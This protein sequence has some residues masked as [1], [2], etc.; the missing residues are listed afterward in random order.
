MKVAFS[1]VSKGSHLLSV[2][3]LCCVFDWVSR[4][5][6]TRL[7]GC[8]VK[9]RNSVICIYPVV[10]PGGRVQVRK[11]L[12]ETKLRYYRFLRSKVVIYF[13]EIFNYCTNRLSQIFNYRTNR[14]SQITYFLTKYYEPLKLQNINLYDFNV[15]KYIVFL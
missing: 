2:P 6:S 10:S 7:S 13:I 3:M 4:H 1:I 15:H 14:Q 12:H 5:Q 8:T 9:Q 11:N